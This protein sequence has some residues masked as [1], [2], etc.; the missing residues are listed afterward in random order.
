MSYHDGYRIFKF[1]THDWEE[2]PFADCR[3]GVPLYGLFE[4]HKNKQ[5]EIYGR[6]K[7]PVLVIDAFM[8]ETDDPFE[9][10]KTE[11]VQMLA[12]IEHP[13]LEEPYEYAEW[14]EDDEEEES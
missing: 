13:A 4:I 3:K 9:L 7:Y 8:E 5:G 2:H 1:T 11:L 10:F 6:N 12:G 14:D